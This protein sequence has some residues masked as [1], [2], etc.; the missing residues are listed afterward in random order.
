MSA[1][2][3]ALGD[4]SPEG[5]ETDFAFR[6]APE[7]LEW[8][9]ASGWML[10]ACRANGQLSLPPVAIQL[11]LNHRYFRPAS[12][13]RIAANSRVRALDNLV[14]N[15]ARPVGDTRI[16]LGSQEMGARYWS[17]RQRRYCPACLHDSA[18]HRLFWDLRFFLTCPIHGLAICGDPGS[19]GVTWTPTDLMSDQEGKHLPIFA[20][21]LDEPSEGFELY[22]MGRLGAAAPIRAPLL[23]G[24]DLGEA[25]RAVQ[26]IGCLLTHP[27]SARRPA[28]RALSRHAALTSARGFIA[29]RADEGHLE[30]EL[31]SILRERIRDLGPREEVSLKGVLGWAARLSH[32]TDNAALHLAESIMG[33]ALAMTGRVRRPLLRRRADARRPAML[34]LK[35]A[36]V[37]AGLPRTATRRAAEFLGIAPADAKRERTYLYAE[38]AAL[39]RSTVD[40]AVTAETVAQ[41]L[42]LRRSALSC[43]VS[44]RLVDPYLMRRPG[45]AAKLFPPATLGMLDPLLAEF[46]SPNGPSVAF[47]AHARYLRLSTGELA[48]RVLEGRERPIGKLLRGKGFRSLCFAACG[49]GHRR[50]SGMPEPRLRSP[51]LSK[52][53]AALQLGIPS[54]AVRW[55]TEIG[56]LSYDGGAMPKGAPGIDRRSVDR[57]GAEFIAIRPL[58]D[59]KGEGTFTL[60]RRLRAAGVAVLARS[61]RHQGMASR[62]DLVELLPELASASGLTGEGSVVNRALPAIRQAAVACPGA[63][64]VQQ[65]TADN[66]VTLVSANRKV[67]VSVVLDEGMRVSTDCTPGRSSRRARI[68]AAAEPPAGFVIVRAD[69]TVRLEARLEPPGMVEAQSLTD[70]LTACLHSLFAM[71]GSA[72][73]DRLERQSRGNFGGR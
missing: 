52:A 69:D 60:A 49:E 44:R 12:A 22:A 45:S 70:F 63:W 28:V 8:E 38:D 47:E 51:G 25:F 72:A 39:I 40:G 24:L 26:T 68:V 43:L 18:H 54:D 73:V 15:T 48:C 64:R 36:A 34:T 9:T 62:S 20:P 29:L 23:D 41:A 31:G 7:P 57:L 33:D 53:D 46:A 59:D 4:L 13:L 17:I 67:T 50:P 6:Y 61:D 1:L 2:H 5:E 66:R 42:G 19:G 21:S 55:L 35:E 56:R 65:D 10:R 30:K 3:D 27:C 37:V 58:V 14:A 16:V 32:K 11:G 71:F